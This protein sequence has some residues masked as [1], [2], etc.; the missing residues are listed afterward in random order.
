SVALEASSHGLAQGRLNGV[1][2][3]VAVLTNLTRDH[4]DYHANQEDYEQAK[5]QLFNF[6]SL[7]HRVL[8]ID[9]DFGARLAADYEDAVTYGADNPKADVCSMEPKFTEAG[10]AFSLAL[11]GQKLSLTT[12]L[13]G[14][15]NLLNLLAVAATLQALG[16]KHEK[17]TAGLAA[18]SSVPGRME[19]TRNKDLP[20]VVIDYAHTPDALRQC[21]AAI[22]RHFP[23]RPVT[24]VF[25]CGGDR[26]P[27]KRPLMGQ[28][29]EQHAS[30]VVLT[31][32]NPRTEAP[33]QILDDIARGMATRP[34]R[35][36]D[37]ALAIAAAIREAGPKGL[38]L[39]AG[40]G[41]ED[42]QVVGEERQRF[43]DR[44][45]V[46]ALAGTV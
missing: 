18:L 37:R 40:K 38:V 1:S 14:E 5:S 17:I 35:I 23:G 44:E 4:L 33:E 13:L 36:V 45:V 22:A 6:P 8:N 7:T 3:D 19:L 15:F 43:S 10:I 39:V 16:R 25:G 34:V 46:A 21:L 2:I 41:H 28:I 20:T 32:D 11:Q 29:A 42:Y 30:R 26:D 31:S 24:C 27:G 9:D 12:A